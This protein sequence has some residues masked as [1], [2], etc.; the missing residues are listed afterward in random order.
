MIHFDTA[1]IFFGKQLLCPTAANVLKELIFAYAS[2]NTDEEEINRC[3]TQRRNKT[4]TKNP[5]PK[6]PRVNVVG[7][8]ACSKTRYADKARNAD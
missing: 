6:K 8:Q 1:L 4:K 7:F 2:S 5:Q 3:L